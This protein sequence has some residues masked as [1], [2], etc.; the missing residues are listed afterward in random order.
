VASLQIP[1][2]NKELVALAIVLGGGSYLWKR[3]AKLRP[4]ALLPSTQAPPISAVQIPSEKLGAIC[5]R[6]PS[7]DWQTLSNWQAPSQSSHLELWQLNADR[8]ALSVE[9]GRN[10][11]G[12]ADIETFLNPAAPIDALFQKGA[13][14]GKGAFGSVSIWNDSAG[15]SFA[16]K[17]MTGKWGVLPGEQ[18]FLVGMALDHE[19]VV[20]IHNL[21]TKIDPVSHNP[22]NYLV[23]EL[24]DGRMLSQASLTDV[25]RLSI[26]QQMTESLDHMFSRGIAPADLHRNN[27]MVTWDGRLK[28]I[29]FGHYR[30][31][32]GSAKLGWVS[33][34]VA[35]ALG[36]VAD[37]L[38]AQGPSYSKL[39]SLLQH[40]LHSGFTS[41]DWRIPLTETTVGPLRKFLYDVALEVNALRTATV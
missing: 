22:V 10:V 25:R 3:I 13:H 37:P 17:E 38:R 16:V 1:T 8:L 2:Q 24:V 33:V 27:I 26:L 39:I 5:T 23:M 18:D 29:D 19:N 9:N 11:I 6:P 40:T 7:T 4:S 28:W 30:R 14:L 15:R 41:R 36:A 34:E 12:S 20:R 21:V 32:D 31:L 35:G